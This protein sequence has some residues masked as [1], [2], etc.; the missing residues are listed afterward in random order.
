[1][2]QKKGQLRCT[3]FYLLVDEELDQ[4]A[5]SHIVVR[6]GK[7]LGL[8]GI[9]RQVA[10]CSPKYYFLIEGYD[11]RVREYIAFFRSGAAA[12]GELSFVRSKYVESVSELR[13]PKGFWCVEAQVTQVA[14]STD[15][16]RDDEEKLRAYKKKHKYN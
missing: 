14:D 16:D 4:Q 11:Y 15:D 9:A 8:R 5:L 2:A 6:M 12:F 1:M 10:P 13:L 3:T 7:S